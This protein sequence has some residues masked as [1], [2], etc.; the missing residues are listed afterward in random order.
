MQ[1]RLLRAGLPDRKS[2]E[3]MAVNWTFVIEL[4]ANLLEDLHVWSSVSTK[5]GAALF[6]NL[7]GLSWT[8]DLY[9]NLDLPSSCV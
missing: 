8:G 2:K 1:H 6:P 7:V 4:N 3:L 5:V 9:Q